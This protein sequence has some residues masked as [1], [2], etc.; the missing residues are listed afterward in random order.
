MWLV[1]GIGNAAGQPKATPPPPTIYQL[2][3]RTIADVKA[4]NSIQDLPPIAAKWNREIRTAMARVDG[5]GSSD[6]DKIINSIE[7]ALKEDVFK[8]FIKRNLPKVAALLDKVPAFLAP[9]LAFLE[10]SG[11]SSTATTFE[12]LKALDDSVQAEISR[13]LTRFL[14]AGWHTQIINQI[15]LQQPG[16]GPTLRAP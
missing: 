5:R 8:D 16:L 14:P 12:Q 13:T 2:A 1:L 9:V 10:A 4:A 15:K 3:E 7:D 6:R 11:P